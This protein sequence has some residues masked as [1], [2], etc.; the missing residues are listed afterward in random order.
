MIT[1]PTNMTIAD[2]CS[3]MKRNEIKVNRDYQRS[4]KVWPAAARSFLIETILLGFP[5]P[6]IA[7]HQITDVKTKKVT[8]EIV[9]GQQRSMAILDFCE[10]QYKLSSAIDSEDLRGSSYNSLD[11]VFKQRFLDYSLSID[12]FIGA[13]VNEVREVFRRINSYTVP[14]NPEEQRHARYQG[15]FKWFAHR[16]VSKYSDSFARIGLF[17]E[18]QFVRMQDTKLVTELVD[19]LVNGIRTTKREHLDALYRKY[20][21]EF[22]G[23]DKTDKSLTMAFDE[24]VGWRD[25]HNTELMKP[26]Q[27]YSLVLA[28]VHMRTPVQK[29]QSLYPSSRVKKFDSKN[30]VPRLTALAEALSVGLDE[31]PEKYR[32]FAEASAEKT[33]VQKPREVRF[34]TYCRALDPK[35]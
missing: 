29:L 7:H 18:K 9:D 34:K 15:A 27:A 11:P 32:R 30:V 33:N 25:L 3:A 2:Y 23:A 6:K 20:E 31:V 12:L 10:N 14:L 17:T 1:I 26:H 16:F 8:K 13:T 24:V 35:E 21:E 5:M 19:A 22:A 4:D 28:L